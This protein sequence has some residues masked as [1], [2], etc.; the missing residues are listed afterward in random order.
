MTRDV[1]QFATSL[2]YGDA[3]SNE[4]ME[5]RR[6]LRDQ[7]INS[8]IFVRFHDPRMAEHVHDYR[9]YR[10]HHSSPENIV[11]FHFSIGSPVSKLFFRVPDKKIMIYHNI[12]P[13]EFFL[14]SHR[15]LTR[16][17][18]KGRLELNLFK[19]KAD[20]ALGDSEFNRRELEAAGY[21]R[22]GV[23]PL[24][25]NLEKF[26]Q[27]GDP[28]VSLMFPEPK[29]TLLFVGRVIPN[30]KFEDVIKCFH[31]YKTLFNPD[32]RL[33]LAGDYRGMERY[34][35]G[36]Q[37][38]V[39]ELELEDVHFTGHIRFPELVAYYD[40][41]DVYLS[42]SEHEGFGVPLLEAFSKDIP[43]IAYAAGA[44]EETLNEGGILLHEK[45]SLRVAGTLEALRTDKGLRESVVAAQRTALGRYDRAN[46]ASILM[47][48]ISQVSQA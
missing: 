48:Y 23:L 2:T 33:I 20:L 6:A 45:D 21:P 12:T 32:S 1:H 31:V 30:K 25:L 26:E 38:L 41:A 36:L 27:P 10:H 24:V 8:E 18:Y 42:L 14:D 22:T 7:G 34:Y 29:W 47:E 17:C 4:M 28:L 11:I 16:E 39:A 46:I 37:N 13:H 35:A 5:I 44:V 19:D 43:V 3:I 9:E 15:I 40:L